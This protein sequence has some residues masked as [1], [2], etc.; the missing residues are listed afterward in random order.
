MTDR[1][2]TEITQIDPAFMTDFVFSQTVSCTEHAVGQPHFA[3]L[4]V[5]SAATA[6]RL[7]VMAEELQR[8]QLLCAAQS[9]RLDELEAREH[10]SWPTRSA[11]AHLEI[12]P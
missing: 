7:D 8:L 11:Y 2:Y 3:P 9:R 5:Q 10:L 4:R 12:D 6:P 1:N